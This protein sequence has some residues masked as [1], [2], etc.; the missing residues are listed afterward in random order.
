M[1]FPLCHELLSW[2]FEQAVYISPPASKPTAESGRRGTADRNST[3]KTAI[4]FGPPE[5]DHQPFIYFQ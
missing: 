1:P 3:K 4:R 2:L 5:D